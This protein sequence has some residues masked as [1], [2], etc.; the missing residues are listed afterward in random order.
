[1]VIVVNLLVSTE[2]VSLHGDKDRFQSDIMERLVAFC[3]NQASKHVSE[4][5]KSPN[6]S[7]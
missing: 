4:H 1:M 7:R 3:K 5:V 6:H 2:F